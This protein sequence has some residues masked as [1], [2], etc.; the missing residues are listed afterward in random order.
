MR[1]C[2]I[3]PCDRLHREDRLRCTE[4]ERTMR[5]VTLALGAWLALGAVPAHAQTAAEML[6]NCQRID[7]APTS[8]EA[9]PVP[10]PSA[11][12]ITCWGAFGALQQIFEIR[13]PPTRSAWPPPTSS[14][15]SAPSELD[16]PDPALHVCLP[17][18]TRRSH[19]VFLFSA[20][21]RQHPD[22]GQRPFAQVAYQTL[23]E[24]YPCMGGG[25]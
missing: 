10:N 22:A 17:A 23:L 11:G 7:D 20:Y 18:A 24:V 12:N 19:L 13:L 14:T 21:M 16:Q 6:G 25:Q 9:I 8:N 2:D 15:P 1:T 4:K 5:K 3:D